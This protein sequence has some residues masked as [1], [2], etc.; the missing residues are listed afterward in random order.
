[1]PD[2]L[3]DRSRMILR[4]AIGFAAE[5]PEDEIPR[6]RGSAPAPLPSFLSAALVPFI[7]F[8]R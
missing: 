5:N 2:R 3:A 4:V 1:M 8:A 6:W 7:R